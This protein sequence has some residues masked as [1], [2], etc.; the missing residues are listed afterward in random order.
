MEISITNI[1][2]EISTFSKDENSLKLEFIV[3]E[4]YPHLEGHFLNNPIVPGVA[5]ITWCLNL[6]RNAFEIQVSQYK[7]SRLKF[8]RPI[9]PLDSVTVSISKIDTKFKFSIFANGEKAAT[10]SVQLISNG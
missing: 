4:N 5:Q 3:P 10:G 6:I 8:T 7:I 1:P 2:P 9:K